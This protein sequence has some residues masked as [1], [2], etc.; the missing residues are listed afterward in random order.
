MPSDSGQT[1]PAPDIRVLVI[2]AVTSLT[3]DGGSSPLRIETTPGKKC[4][5]LDSTT[6]VA[7]GESGLAIGDEGCGRE[8]AIRN[9]EQRY[10][11]GERMFRGRLALIWKGPG[12]LIVVDH[13]P[14]E[15]Y[16]VGLINSEISSSWPPEAIMAQ[17]VAARTY[18]LSRIE[19][20]RQGESKLPYD[21]RS[22]VLDQ[23]Y[24]GAQGEDYP[25]RRA[26]AATRGDV[27]KR[28]GKIFA[29]Y[30]HSCCGGQTE[31]A[32]NVWPGEKDSPAVKDDY[33]RRSPKRL[34]NLRIPLAGFAQT[35][36][37][38]G[39]DVADVTSVASSKHDDS[40][41]TELILVG[42]DGGIKIVRA[43]D[44]RRMFGYRNIK[45]TWF[46]V[47]TDRGSIE[48]G[49]RGYGHGVGMCQWGAKAMA[50]SGKSYRD[51]LKF[52]YPDA[53]II[54]AY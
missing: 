40:P 13:L 54:K 5:G 28:G 36:R 27:L 4:T 10:R 50:E 45:S 12:R 33:C 18:A 39:V 11:V 24:Q 38:N 15:D 35:L 25:S 31:H 26:V 42:D 23:V 30:Y 2:D 32:R 29:S 20:A 51:I 34:W 21:V 46:D 37:D 19:R 1:T 8:I 6:T 41:R 52:Y 3:V 47:R 48:F 9:D 7:A 53:Y 22:T 49:G 14:L 16:L 44:L 43:T 17:A